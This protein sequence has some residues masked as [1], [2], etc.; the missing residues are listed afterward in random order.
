MR[1][2]PKLAR[3]AAE[4]QP[5]ASRAEILARVAQ[6]ALD[7][8]DRRVRA[9]E[10]LPARREARPER[11]PRA[12]STSPAERTSPVGSEASTALLPT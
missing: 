10:I 5:P 8:Y 3:R 12:G 7:E 2:S 6:R 11:A 4:A 1:L 9:G